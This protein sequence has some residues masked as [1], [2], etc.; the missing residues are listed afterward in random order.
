MT[1][2]VNA[3]RS[4]AFMRWDETGITD[5][6]DRLASSGMAPRRDVTTWSP[7]TAAEF[8]RLAD[9][10]DGWSFVTELLRQQSVGPYGPGVTLDGYE[11][12]EGD[13]EQGGESSAPARSP[14]GEA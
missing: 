4:L 5:R 11:P 6:D 12:V 14:E 2:D 3:M 1:T 7:V 10:L 8:R 9:A 13:T